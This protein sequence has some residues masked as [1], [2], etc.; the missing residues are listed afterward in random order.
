MTTTVAE[1]FTEGHRLD[2]IVP[3]SRTDDMGTVGWKSMRDYHKAVV[4]ILCGALAAG[5]AVDC[6]ITQAKDDAGTGAKDISG[7]AVTTLDGDDDNTISAIELDASELDVTNQFD[8]INV[9]LSCGGNVACLTA[10]LLVRYQPRFKEVDDT[11]I[12]Y[13]MI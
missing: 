8:Y 10:A 3:Q 12:T 9:E 1:Y 4:I 6:K 2:Q 11:N 5:A 7:K 13:L